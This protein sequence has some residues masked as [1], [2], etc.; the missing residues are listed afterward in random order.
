[1]QPCAALSRRRCRSSVRRRR[2]T[3]EEVDPNGHTANRRCLP[4]QEHPVAASFGRDHV[5]I[6]QNA[7]SASRRS[8]LPPVWRQNLISNGAHRC[9]RSQKCQCDCRLLAESRRTVVQ[10][11]SQRSLRRRGWPRRPLAVRPAMRPHH[12]LMLNGSTARRTVPASA[13]A[14]GRRPARKQPRLLPTST[15]A[16][17]RC[18][19]YPRARSRC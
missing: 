4:R 18:D 19:Q 14:A 3:A 8:R 10:P 7:P 16:L 11:P 9:C 5:E 1:M 2:G 12:G 15:P 13:S 17:W 6:A